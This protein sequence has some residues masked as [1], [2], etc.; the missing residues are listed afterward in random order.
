MKNFHP[1]YCMKISRSTVCTCIGLQ[2]YL[3]KYRCSAYV[4]V[5]QLCASPFHGR[6]SSTL[7][8]GVLLQGRCAAQS[9]IS[10]RT[11]YRSWVPRLHISCSKM[12]LVPSLPLSYCHLSYHTA[13]ISTV[14]GIY[15]AVNRLS[16]RA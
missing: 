7:R 11:R 8:S 12:S 4:L 15:M 2:I 10:Q 6:I 16:Q 3:D 9:V 13:S 14:R 1:N 5:Q